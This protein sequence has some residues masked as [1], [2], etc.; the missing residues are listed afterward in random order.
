MDRG[1]G[2]F[3]GKRLHNLREPLGHRDRT[4]PTTGQSGIRRGVQLSS[5]AYA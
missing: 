5:S 1:F 4:Q 3:L 2:E